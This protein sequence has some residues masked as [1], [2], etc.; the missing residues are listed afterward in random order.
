MHANKQL[1]NSELYLAKKVNSKADM[2]LN[3]TVIT[4]S[5]IIFSYNFFKIL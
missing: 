2:V 5:N 3:R 4:F 1:V